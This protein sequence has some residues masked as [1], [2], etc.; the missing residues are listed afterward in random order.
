MV[1]AQARRSRRR[2]AVRVAGR[3]ARAS[4]RGG[5]LGALQ[6]HDAGCCGDGVGLP[7]AW[8]GLFPCRRRR[9][10]FAN[11][12]GLL[13]DGSPCAATRRGAA[14]LAVGLTPSRLRRGPGRLRGF[15]WAVFGPVLDQF[16]IPTLPHLRSKA[17]RSTLVFHTA[18]REPVSSLLLE[19][20]L[21]TPDSSCSDCSA[22]RLRAIAQGS[23]EQS[24]LSQTR[25]A[26]TN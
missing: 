19:R 9:R 22:Y 13:G 1:G 4:R 7:R 26:H 3:A 5:G 25:R 17:G 23:G 2:R 24:H 21:A 20:R 11:P 18:P 10:S 15:S 12:L 6:W 16:L 8:G 14:P